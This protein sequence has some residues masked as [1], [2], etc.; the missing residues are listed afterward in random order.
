[1][2][3]TKRAIAMESLSIFVSAIVLMC[4]GTFSDV[5]NATERYGPSK[6]DLIGGIS[7][8]NDGRENE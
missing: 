5:A 7:R 1:M 8:W 2:L 3:E 6:E 4:S